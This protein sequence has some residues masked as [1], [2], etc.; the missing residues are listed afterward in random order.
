MNKR[1]E[2]TFRYFHVDSLKSYVA[3]IENRE[4]NLSFSATL[5]HM[6][7]HYFIVCILSW[8]TLQTWGFLS[9][10]KHSKVVLPDDVVLL[11]SVTHPLPILIFPLKS[12]NILSSL[13]GK[14][15]SGCRG[16]STPCHQSGE[17]DRS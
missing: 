2:G 14:F 8:F 15:G 3:D 7:H 4:K 1:C 9:K 11:L 16:A 12:E 17:L 13:K 6:I 5:V 10:K